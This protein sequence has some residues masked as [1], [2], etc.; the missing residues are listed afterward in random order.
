[1]S[2]AV[3]DAICQEAAAKEADVIVMASHGYSGVKHLLLGSVVEHVLR[4][5]DR[6]VLVVRTK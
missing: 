4:N 1:M 3:H 5:A 6:P 2:G